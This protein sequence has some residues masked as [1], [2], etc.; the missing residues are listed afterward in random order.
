MKRLFSSIAAVLLTTTLTAF[1]AQQGIYRLITLPDGSQTV[2]ELKGDALSHYWQTE[3]GRCFVAMGNDVYK[4]LPGKSLQKARTLKHNGAKVSLATSAAA[5]TNQSEADA[6]FHG[7]KK[8]LIILVQFQDKEFKSGHDQAFYNAMTNEVGFTS[9]AGHVGSVKDYFLA[10]SNGVFELDFDVVGPYTLPQN[11]AYYGANNSQGSDSH[12]GEM[13]VKACTY[14]D[15]DVNF[16]DYDWNGDGELEQVYVLYAGMGEANGGDENTI[17][18]HEW[19]LTAAYETTITLDGIV[20]D[21]YACGPELDAYSVY[22]R[23]T[24]KSQYYERTGGIGTLCHEFSHCLGLRDHY[25]TQ[26]Q[27]YTGTGYYD[28]M[29]SGSYNGDSFRPCN[30]TAYELMF[31]GWTEPIELNEPTTVK[32]MKSLSD[33]GQTFIIYND[34]NKD[35]FYLLENRQQTGWDTALP[36]AGLLITHVDYDSTVWKWNIINSNYT[37]EFYDSVYATNDHERYGII[38]ADASL[39]IRSYA[40]CLIRLLMTH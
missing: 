8:G 25:D 11:Y 9:S 23:I 4:E 35:E 19:N 31:A 3:D 10:Q 40:G 15:A 21:T 27:R 36:G 20:I 39:T 13:I 22:N 1:P 30:F 38:R 12:S 26:G 34:A 7:K 29:C 32:D 17:W 18:P 16:A 37:Y 14:A 24:R 33:Y 6:T 5:K 28:V 2:G